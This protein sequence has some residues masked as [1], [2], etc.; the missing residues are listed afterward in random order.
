MNIVS[1][2]RCLFASYVFEIVKKKVHILY[3]EPPSNFTAKN[4]L[5]LHFHRLYHIVKIL[6]HIQWNTLTRPRKTGK[7]NVYIFYKEKHTVKIE[8]SITYKR[9]YCDKSLVNTN[10][11]Y[12]NCLD[13]HWVINRKQILT[14]NATNSNKNTAHK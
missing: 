7:E 6:L 3:V 8:I 5:I 4:D 10:R 1:N 14:I 11:K 2:F 9:K 12:K 13:Q